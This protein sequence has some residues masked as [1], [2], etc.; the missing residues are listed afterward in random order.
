MV[1]PDVT[2]LHSPLFLRIHTLIEHVRFLVFL[3][4]VHTHRI[5]ENWMF[6][7][8]FI[9]HL[10][11]WFILIW[12]LWFF[13]KSAHIWHA[14]LFFLCIFSRNWCWLAFGWRNF[15]LSRRRHTFLAFK[16]L[17]R[18]FFLWFFVFRWH[19][20]Q[21]S[22]RTLILFVLSKSSDIDGLSLVFSQSLCRIIKLRM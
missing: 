2:K 14:W 5:H 17:F 19:W 12:L 22:W 11:N 6:W 7:L 20:I 15:S 18:L 8:Q 21:H 3:L 13:T 1:F 4:L 9:R 10:F 16:W